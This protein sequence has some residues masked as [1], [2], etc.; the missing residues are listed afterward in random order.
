MTI[1]RK[2]FDDSNVAMEIA[3][4]YFIQRFVIDP[5]VLFKAV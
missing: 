1:E 4:R 5:Q 2:Q 3:L